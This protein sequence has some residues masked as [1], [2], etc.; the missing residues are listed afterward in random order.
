MFGHKADRCCLWIGPGGWAK[1]R[2]QGRLGDFDVSSL[3]TELPSAETE[4]TEGEGGVGK[5]DSPHLPRPPW[6][7]KSPHSSIHKE[8][9]C[10]HLLI[11]ICKCCILGSLDKPCS[12]GILPEKSRT[13]LLQLSKPIKRHQGEKQVS[14]W[15]KNLLNLTFSFLHLPA[16]RPWIIW[17]WRWTQWSW[18]RIGGEKNTELQKWDIWQFQDRLD[19]STSI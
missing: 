8:W 5:D 9:K 17:T 3:R 4:E 2:S 14:V 11:I 19:E 12:L 16:I 1:D 6:I 13:K 15:C 7:T 18:R 10:K